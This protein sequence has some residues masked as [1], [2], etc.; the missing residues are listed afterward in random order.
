MLGSR[1]ITAL[2]LLVVLAGLLSVDNRW[3]FLVFLTLVVALTLLEWLRL[4]APRVKF[5]PEIGA[6]LLGAATLFQAWLWTDST[7]AWLA[8]FEL[9]AIVSGLVWVFVVPVLVASAKLDQNKPSLG[10]SFFAPVCLFATWGALAQIWLT[11]GVWELLSLLALVWIADI[12]AYFG[13]RQ[14]GRRKLAPAISPGKTREGAA[15]GL[16]GVIV[17][18]LLTAHLS[19]SY[20]SRVLD[21]WG[22][23]GVVASAVLLG[24][25]AVLGDLFE[26]MLKRQAQ[27]KDS[28]RLLPGH[29]GVYDRVDAVVAV[30]PVAYLIV[31]DFW[32][33]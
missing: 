30:V 11:G 10:W 3:P 22:W 23:A 14:F 25:I 18:M 17:W 13:G 26:S 12:F 29:G 33:Q 21:L 28:G 31:S 7:N 15:I 1:L 24:L 27:V 19:G 5:L 9:T 4:C 20:S 32:Y 2:I 16:L 6:A 8:T